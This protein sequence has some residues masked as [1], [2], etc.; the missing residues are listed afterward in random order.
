MVVGWGV[1]S[2]G[3]DGAGERMVRGKE[4]VWGCHRPPSAAIGGKVKSDALKSRR[5]EWP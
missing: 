2:G 5:G 1:G 4:R 3:A